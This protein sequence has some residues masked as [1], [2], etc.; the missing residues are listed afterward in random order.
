MQR[1]GTNHA[2]KL[3]GLGYIILHTSATDTL[4]LCCKQWMQGN[5]RYGLVALVYR[6]SAYGRIRNNIHKVLYYIVHD[7]RHTRMYLKC[8]VQGVVHAVVSEYHYPVI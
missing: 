1:V 2:P 7:L 4:R 5:I 6:Q 8:L 3:K